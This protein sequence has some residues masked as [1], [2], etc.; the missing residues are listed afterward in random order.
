MYKN[1]VVLAICLLFIKTL[2][3]QNEA[4]IK[5]YVPN[6]TNVKAH[7]LWGSWGLGNTEYNMEPIGNG[8]W[9]VA[10]EDLSPG[11]HYY[12]LMV[13][14]YFTL[15]PLDEEYWAAGHHVNGIDVPDN[16][17]DAYI[18]KNV[19]HGTVRTHFYNYTVN[20][21]TTTRRCLVYL[22]PMY[23][24]ATETGYPVLYLQH[25]MNEDENAWFEQ[26]KVNFIMDNLIAEGLA[27]PMIIVMENG[28]TARSSSEF[29]NLFTNGLKPTIEANF[30]TATDKQ[31]RAIAGLSMGAG[32]AGN[33]VF[34]NHEYFAYLG[35]F[36]G[37]ANLNSTTKAG[38]NDN[39]ELLWYGYG[40]TDEGHSGIVSSINSTNNLK[41]NNTSKEYSGGHEWQVWR[42][43]I[44]DFAQLLFKPYEYENPFTVI[45][46]N[47]SIAEFV[48][49]PNPTKGSLKLK[50][51][52]VLSNDSVVLSIHD[53]SGKETGQFKGNVSLINNY[54]QKCFLDAQPGIYTIKM[55]FN[56]KWH[57]Q[58]IVKQ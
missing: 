2:L 28:M 51:N 16:S 4:I 42:K 30:N 5:A 56:N 38:L 34:N 6:A 24:T 25:G 39:L 14:N 18:G 1:T 48:L 29:E 21:E 23:S 12:G 10:I 47:N 7:G 44:Y 53:I 37:Y 40:D 46:Q 35:L 19:P 52:S 27:E 50:L 32:Q 26:G 45:S 36:S 55:A 17:F 58:K 9:Q 41:V 49:Y 31:K 3:A 33:L 11:F 43:C 22:P 8:Y 57:Q 54:L 20:N 13:D 15:N